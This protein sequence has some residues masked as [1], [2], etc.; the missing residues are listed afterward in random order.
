MENFATEAGVLKIFGRHYKTGETIPDSMILK[1]KE[2]KNFL[3]AMGIVRQL[4]FSLFDILIHEKNYTEED[5]HSILQ[6]VR[7][8]VAVVIP[9]EYNRFQ[10]GF[11]HIFSGGYAAGYYSYKWAEVMS[12]DAFF[13]FVDKG[14]FNSELCN[15]YFTEILEKGGS[16]NAMVL[17][18]RL[19]GRDP[20]VG[21][22]LKLYELKE[23]Y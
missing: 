6:N 20:E 5:V 13:A 7:K 22:L 14:I 15:A 8:E 16:E 23:S 12:A 10:N 2:T 4:E 18:K 1:L 3:S 17:F 21:S 9:P 19:L 11:S